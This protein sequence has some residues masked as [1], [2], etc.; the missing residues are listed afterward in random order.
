MNRMPEQEPERVRRKTS[1]A[2]LEKI[3][4]ELQR[5]VRHYGAGSREDL[6]RRLAA[7]ENEWSIERFLDTNASILGLSGVVL[8]LTV[9]KRWLLLTAAVSGFLLQHALTGWCPPVPVFR[10]LGVRTRSEIDREKFALKALRG[11]FKDIELPERHRGDAA[12]G[13]TMRAISA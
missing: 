7:L 5:S 2:Q 12:A 11:D 6:N 1:A 4:Q 9:S 3:E 13:D 8:G 10:R